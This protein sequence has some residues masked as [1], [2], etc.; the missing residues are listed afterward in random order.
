MLVIHGGVGEVEE[1][2]NPLVGDPHVHGI[3]VEAHH[4]GCGVVGGL[5]GREI[6]VVVDEAAVCLGRVLSPNQIILMEFMC[7]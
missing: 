3:H 1:V 7:C 6:G 2:G 5:E 4:G